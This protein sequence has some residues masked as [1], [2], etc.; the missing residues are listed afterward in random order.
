MPDKRNDIHILECKTVFQGYFRV[1]Q[2]RLKHKLFNG[3][4][5]S[6]IQRE[7]FERGHAVSLLPYDPIRDEVVLLEQFRPGA[8]ASGSEPWLIECVAGIM[9]P[10]E[11]PEAVARR[12][13]MEETGLTISNLM[14]MHSMF[15]SPGAVSERVELFIGRI[16]AANA[17]GFYGLCEEQEDIRVF[18]Q[19]YDDAID[20]LN[21]GMIVNCHTILSIQWLALNRNNV[22]KQWS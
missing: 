9:E 6:E 21:R 19:S 13:A 4:W 3:G 17:G 22:R 15:V 1:D 2:Y 16:D 20:L 7:V 12:E 10:G 14:H 18:V 11:S 8:L 5:S